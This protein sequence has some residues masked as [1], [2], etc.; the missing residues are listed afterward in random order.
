M[1]SQIEFANIKE[2][3]DYVSM[4]RLLADDFGELAV[5]LGPLL[6]LHDQGSNRDLESALEDDTEFWNSAMSAWIGSCCVIVG[7][8][9]ENS[10][11]T[12]LQ[13]VRTFLKRYRKDPAKSTADKLDACLDA[14]K[15]FID[16]VL[17]LRHNVF[18]HTTPNTQLWLAFG[19][20]KLTW[21]DFERYWSDVARVYETLERSTFGQDYGP[22]FSSTLLQEKIDEARQFFAKL[23][24]LSK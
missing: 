12:P 9:H 7:R 17:E 13:K 22:K 19:F 6:A 14:N 8:I 21:K 15:G 3:S 11:K 5:F 18:A 20:D 4:C 23:V 24:K 2:K 16:H 10:S 1:Q